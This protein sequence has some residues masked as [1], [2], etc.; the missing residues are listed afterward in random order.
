MAE[1]KIAGVCAGVARYLGVDVTIVRL[2]WVLFVL[3]HGFGLLAYLVAWIIM[4]R[5]V[6]LAHRAQYA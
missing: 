3:L 2:V 4:P 1:K 6:D 5:D